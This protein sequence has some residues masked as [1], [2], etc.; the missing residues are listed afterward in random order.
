[1]KRIAIEAVKLERKMI[2]HDQ[3]QT[4]MKVIG[5]AVRIEIESAGKKNLIVIIEVEAVALMTIDDIVEVVAGVSHL[6]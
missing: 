2:V 4:A 5:V 6:L 1:M 3:G